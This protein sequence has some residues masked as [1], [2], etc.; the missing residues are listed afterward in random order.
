MHIVLRV[1]KLG[2]KGSVEGTPERRRKGRLDAKVNFIYL[3]NLLSFGLA[4][5]EYQLIGTHTV[6]Y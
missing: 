3:M 6:S 5:I 2:A 4:E 1:E